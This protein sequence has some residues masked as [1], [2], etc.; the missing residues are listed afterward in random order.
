MENLRPRHELFHSFCVLPKLEFESQ[1]SG[2]QTVLLLR[3]HP[4]TQLPWIL[5]GLFLFVLLGLLNILFA[6]SFTAA[7]E[8]FINVSLGIFIFAYYWFKFLSYYFNVGIVT[9]S[10]VIDIDLHAVIY[11]EVSEAQLKNV[12]DITAKSGGYIPSVFNFGNVYVQTAGAHVNIEF[13]NTPRP[14]EVV[15]IINQLLHP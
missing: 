14:A 15:K 13:D 10:R 4:I 12:E 5:N 2:E 6:A 1:V 7:Q 11:K 8:L 3:A 9:Q